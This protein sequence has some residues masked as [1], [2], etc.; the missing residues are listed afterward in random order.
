[1]M[2]GACYSWVGCT[3]GWEDWTVLECIKPLFLSFLCT[4]ATLEAHKRLSGWGRC[5]FWLC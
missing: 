2:Y 4:Q 3:P 5:K 1:M